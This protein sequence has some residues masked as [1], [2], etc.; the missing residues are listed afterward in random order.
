MEQTFKYKIR[1][2]DNKELFDKVIFNYTGLFYKIYN[3]LELN[4]DK[5]FI[6]SCLAKHSVGQSPPPKGR[7]LSREAQG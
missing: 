1:T 4:E 6:N 5:E 2:V 7:G 3:N